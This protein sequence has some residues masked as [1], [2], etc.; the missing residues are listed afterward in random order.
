MWIGAERRL[1]DLIL[2]ELIPPGSDGRVPGAGAAGVADFFPTADRYAP[3]PRDAVN[4][5]L[6]AVSAKAADFSA[7]DREGRARVLREVEL[8]EGGAFSTLVRLAYM[9]YYSRSEIRP[10]FGVGADAVHP[11]GYPVAP[12][13]EALLDELTEPVRSRGPSYRG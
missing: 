4:A 1:L 8:E 9:G 5:I 3:N 6:A 11:K 12:E 10:L 2:D 7:L 13:D